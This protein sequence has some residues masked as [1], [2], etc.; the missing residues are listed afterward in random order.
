[1]LFYKCILH[2]TLRECNKVTATQ[3]PTVIKNL[4]TEI[5][6]A[7]RLRRPNVGEGDHGMEVC[8]KQVLNSA[9]VC[10]LCASCLLPIQ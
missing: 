2:P 6:H 4:A 7:T 8:D 10:I 5:V 1:M 9:P 3:N